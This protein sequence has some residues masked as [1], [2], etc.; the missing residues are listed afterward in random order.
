[1][2]LKAG[3]KISQWEIVPELC[4]TKRLY[5][6]ILYTIKEIATKQLIKCSLQKK[7]RYQDAR[8]EYSSTYPAIHSRERE[9]C[10]NESVCGSEAEARF[11]GI[12]SF[13]TSSVLPSRGHVRE[14]GGRAGSGEGPGPQSPPLAWLRCAS[15]SQ[16]CSCWEMLWGG[17]NSGSQTPAVEGRGRQINA[18]MNATNP[19][20]PPS[21]LA[22]PAEAGGV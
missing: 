20:R 9:V 10:S 11:L 21:Y 6:K 22:P 17:D 2:L 1:M 18:Q 19:E 16:V 12:P 8:Q 7:R 3:Q 13:Q 15:P 4:Y 14:G 5:V